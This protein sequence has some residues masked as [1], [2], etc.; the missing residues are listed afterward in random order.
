M[1][2]MIADL[3]K[4]LQVLTALILLCG[5]LAALTVHNSVVGPSILS[6][7]SVEREY[8]NI[9][10][11]YWLG[12]TGTFLLWNLGIFCVVDE[13]EEWDLIDRWSGFTACTFVGTVVSLMTYVAINNKGVL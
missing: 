13:K 8:V 10:L 2:K 3:L 9:F 12:G 1:R 5:I 11:A 7:I 4:K 6:G